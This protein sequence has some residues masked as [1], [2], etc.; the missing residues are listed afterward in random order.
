[1][2]DL[3]IDISRVEVLVDTV[4]AASTDINQLIELQTELGACGYYLADSDIA[5]ELNEFAQY[6]I[7]G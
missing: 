5:K 1:M 7:R 6:E 2:R 3:F 4:K